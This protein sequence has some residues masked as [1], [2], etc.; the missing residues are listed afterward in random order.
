MPFTPKRTDGVYVRIVLASVSLMYGV[1]G[2][3]AATLAPDV[4]PPL[5]ASEVLSE[6]I[7]HTIRYQNDAADEVEEYFSPDGS[8]HG[9]SRTHGAYRSDWQLRF[10]HYLCI[11]AT[12]PTDSGCVR[13][14]VRPDGRVEFR[15]DIGE[16][17]GPFE[18]RRGN[19][20]KL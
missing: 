11:V 16:M 17:E 19:P 15:L 8:V 13:V 10:G 12:K 1:V 2:S 5:T 6:I 18:L 20:D 4:V 14:A 3:A 7:D 9:R